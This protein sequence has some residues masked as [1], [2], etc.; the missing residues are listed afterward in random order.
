MWFSSSWLCVP[1][2]QNKQRLFHTA[3]HE[4]NE[5]KKKKKIKW[6]KWKMNKN[7]F[8][9]RKMNK[10]GASTVASNQALKTFLSWFWQ[11]WNKNGKE[12]TYYF[13]YQRGT[14][15][16]GCAVRK[17]PLLSLKSPKCLVFSSLKYVLTSIFYI[18]KQLLSTS[19]F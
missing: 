1:P 8:E 3:R 10:L 12:F 9:W 16:N 5:E 17:Q 11:W 14:Y 6:R 15:L 19:A 4:W 18:H 2:Y 13:I 7:K